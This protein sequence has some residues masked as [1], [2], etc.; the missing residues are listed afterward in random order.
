MLSSQRKAYGEATRLETDEVV[1]S[2]SLQMSS[3]GLES[4]GDIGQSTSHRQTAE[5]V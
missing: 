1:F 4:L 2:L 3:N 5:H